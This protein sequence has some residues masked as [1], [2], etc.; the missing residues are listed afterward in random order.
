MN[1]RI[2]F[3]WFT[4]PTDAEFE[5]LGITNKKGDKGV[6]LWKMVKIYKALKNCY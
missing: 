6:A 5:K 1:L 3:K 4:P 2:E